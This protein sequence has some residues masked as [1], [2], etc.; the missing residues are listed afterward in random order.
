MSKSIIQNE[1]KC[2][3]CGCEYG[4][5]KHHIMAGVANRKL[6]EKYGIWVWL[7]GNKCHRG[8]DGAQYN[9]ELNLELK[10][11][12]QKAFEDIYGHKM[13]MDTFRKNYL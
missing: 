4:L 1:K 7:C 13:W 10:Q 5:E 12:A 11:I 9:K 3:N 2:F 8:V 6:S